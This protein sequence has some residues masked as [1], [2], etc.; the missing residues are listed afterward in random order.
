MSCPAMQYYHYLLNNV[1]TVLT[2]ILWQ[3]QIKIYPC[4]FEK[5]RVE[6]ESRFEMKK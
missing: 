2:S 6:A 3:M 5:G 4:Y 1:F